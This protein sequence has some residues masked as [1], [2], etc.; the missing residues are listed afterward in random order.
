MGDSTESPLKLE[1]EVTEVTERPS[2]AT[3][4]DVS[5]G[6]DQCLGP[7]FYD[8]VRRTIELDPTGR[9]FVLAHLAKPCPGCWQAIQALDPW[10]GDLG[11]V[12]DPLILAVRR[13]GSSP[14]W[15]RANH[16]QALRLASAHQGGI[17]H[18]TLEEVRCTARDVEDLVNALQDTV[19]LCS[20]DA[21][22][23]PALHEVKLT[24]R[25]ELYAAEILLETQR[26]DEARQRLAAL[27]PKANMLGTDLWATY[28]L[29]AARETLEPA[30]S[31]DL[32][33]VLSAFQ[34]L[35]RAVKDPRLAVYPALA[36]RR[37]EL[38]VS[39]ARLFAELAREDTLHSARGL[40]MEVERSA[41][42]K[43]FPRLHV[44]HQL[45]HCE[46][47]FFSMLNE[48]TAPTAPMWNRLQRLKKRADRDELPTA[49]GFRIAHLDQLLEEHLATRSQ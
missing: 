16:R 10:V 23:L 14:D 9:L 35:G 49:L 24:V 36:E 15:L 27:R 43:G 29:L 1:P 3:L 48:P 47:D 41:L 32:R 33:A 8:T 45:A 37:L 44:E 31:R 40:L 19:T 6:E 26:F 7:K 34:T 46:V 22:R 2:R 30:E 28:C 25:A 21:V 5:A 4:L 38:M 13:I 42:L 17:C 39:T 18:L 11:T 12:A 20:E